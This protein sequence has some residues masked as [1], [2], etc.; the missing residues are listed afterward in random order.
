MIRFGAHMYQVDPLLFL[1]RGT[2]RDKIALNLIDKPVRHVHATGWW[3][4]P[5]I[6]LFL[7]MLVST[8]YNNTYKLRK[9]LIHGF[10]FFFYLSVTL[11][12]F[13]RAESVENSI[14]ECGPM[15]FHLMLTCC[16]GTSGESCWFN[17]L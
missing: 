2:H 12:P 5:F 13:P 7:T 3:M 6:C 8:A 4:S 11:A 15:V 14:F 1:I 16:F 17:L 10:L 9:I